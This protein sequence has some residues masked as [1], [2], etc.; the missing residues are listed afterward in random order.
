[1]ILTIQ[2]S[3][4]LEK[5]DFD[6]IN[7]IHEREIL[8][9]AYNA[10]T[11]T[12]G[13][14][15]Y[16]KNFNEESFMF[17]SNPM[18]KSI[19]DNMIAAKRISSNEIE[20]VVP[21]ITWR[22]GSRYKQYDDRQSLDFLTSTTNQNG[23]E[24]LPM[25]VVNSEGNVYKCLC[26]NISSLSNVEPKGDFST[27]NGFISTVDENELDSYLWKYMYNIRSTN[28][29]L[30]NDWIPVPTS[31]YFI[32]YNTSESNLVEGALAKIV[33]TNRGS[34]YFNSNVFSESYNTATNIITITSASFNSNLIV[35]NMSISGNGISP[36]TYITSVDPFFRRLTLS[37]ATTLG[38]VSNSR[39]SVV[40][41]IDVEGDGNQDVLA[42]A[43]LNGDEIEKIFVTS[44]GT[45]YTKANVSIYGTGTGATARVVLPPKYGHGFN[46]AKELNSNKIMVVQKIGDVDSTE[47]NL[48]ST[49]TSFRQY[50][51][52]SSPHKYGNTRPI[53]DAD[54]NTVM[55]QTFDVTLVP[56][57]D[58]VLNDIVFQGNSFEDYN[59]LGYVHSQDV[60]NTVRLVNV[61][62]ELQINAVLNGL[63][64]PTSRTVVS[65]QN[66]DFEPYSGDILFVQ[67]SSA[68]QRSDGQAENI[69]FVINF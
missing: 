46:P 1:M 5:S 45:N 2:M 10:V 47:G 20:M 26:N 13:G 48:I 38:S 42:E 57:T 37:T 6:K 30:T 4:T 62:G 15:N 12:E 56:G 64:N 55:K 40:T 39:I 35:E 7:S 29:F 23:V 66:P 41:R 21:R 16:L 49:S 54:A 63:S 31:V 44:I 11:M 25:Y 60:N 61:D 65:F 59:F 52:L 19:S 69:R 14:W 68:V 36:G 8:E 34:G 43:R 18:V 24:I 33:M 17:S 50:G 58:Y 27:S 51:L 67:N 53:V 32:E 28:K 3:I 9:N 22:A